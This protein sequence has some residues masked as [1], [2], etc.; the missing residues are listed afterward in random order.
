MI[1]YETDFPEYG[2]QCELVKPWRGFG[3][4]E[5]ISRSSVAEQR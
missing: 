4:Q 1:M 3:L 2:R 5:A